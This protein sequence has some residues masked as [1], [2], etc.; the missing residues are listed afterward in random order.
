MYR[1]ITWPQLRAGQ[2]TG[3][4]PPQRGS[5]AQ[6]SADVDDAWDYYLRNYNQGRGVVLIGHSQGAGQVSRLVRTKI[7]GSAVE[8]QVVAV[9][10][11]GGSVTVPKGKDV[12]GTFQAIKPCS[13]KSQ[14]GCVVTYGSY[15][16]TLPPN[17]TGQAVG[18]GPSA[19]SSG[20]NQG[21][22]V[23]P[24]ALLAGKASGP[25]TADSYW[26]VEPPISATTKAPPRWSGKEI[27]Y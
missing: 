3:P 14:V 19:N 21:V 26:A 25:A 24:A 16:A 18:T 11:L 4:A 10:I 2:G 8:K 22:C 15:R 1:Q 20:A 12:G 7:E 17:P 23:D 13:S 27:I 6:G 9:Y 5:R